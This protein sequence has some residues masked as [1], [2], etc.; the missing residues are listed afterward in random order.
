MIIVYESVDEGV[1]TRLVKW[2]EHHPYTLVDLSHVVDF[3]YLGRV[4]VDAA[5]QVREGLREDV[6]VVSEVVWLYVAAQTAQFDSY[7]L[8]GLA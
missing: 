5:H 4:D 3:L 1:Q 7:C 6:L 8:F 2:H